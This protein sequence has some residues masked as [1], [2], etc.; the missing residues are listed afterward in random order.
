MGHHGTIGSSCLLPV[1]PA[2]FAILLVAMTVAHAG[3]Q[4]FADG[5]EDLPLMP[6]LQN[7]K[8]SLTVFDSPYGS[9]VE[10]MAEGAISP[11]DITSFYA[12]TLP[13]LGWTRTTTTT[14]RR[15]TEELTLDL[16]HSNGATVVRFRIAPRD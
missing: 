16:G 11:A 8:D 12:R 5:I 6:G 13:Q 2:A 14:F 1:L 9:F 7:R 15:D 10:S 4:G 3:T